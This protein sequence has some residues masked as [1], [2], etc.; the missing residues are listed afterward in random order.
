MSNNHIDLFLNFQ[1]LQ[2]QRLTHLQ[3][4]YK[5]DVGKGQS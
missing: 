4:A 1:M 2:K 3:S 5:K